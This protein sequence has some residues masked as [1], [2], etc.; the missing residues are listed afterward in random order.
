MI[1]SR[2]DLERSLLA[3]PF[4]AEQ[5][6]LYARV[7]LDGGDAAAALAQ[8]EILAKQSPGEARPQVGAARALLAL[9]RNGEALQ[10]YTSARNL[11]NFAADDELESHV[12]RARQ[13][14]PSRLSV[15]PGGRAADNVVQIAT[16][17]R[18]GSTA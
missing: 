9:G 11:S 17:T 5:R 8:F 10:R 2:E 4:N 6:A 13:A 14:Q 18:S 7:L 12:A 16:A 3:D 1:L 15:L